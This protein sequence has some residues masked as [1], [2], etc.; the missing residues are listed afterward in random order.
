MYIMY[1]TCSDDVD[2]Y[3]VILFKIVLPGLTECVVDG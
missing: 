3:E 1:M 2:R